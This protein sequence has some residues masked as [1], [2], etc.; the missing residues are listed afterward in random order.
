MY[1]L[2]TKPTQ[3][4]LWIGGI[5]E[6]QVTGKSYKT[7]FTIVLVAMYSS[8]TLRICNS[9]SPIFYLEENSQA[10]QNG[11]ASFILAK[12]QIKHHY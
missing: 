8:F 2:C 7:S 5:A 12:Q 9:T 10:T 11:S 4:L 6:E 3:C 1:H